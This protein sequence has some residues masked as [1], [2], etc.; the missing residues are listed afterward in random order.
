MMPC[1]VFTATIYCVAYM[2]PNSDERKRGSLVSL[3]RLGEE[4][5]AQK[6]PE[7]ASV[8]KTAEPPQA[9]PLHR[10]L[11]GRPGIP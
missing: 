6:V 9:E 3:H 8:R 11:H 10:P 5:E 4:A 1:N 2:I 7:P